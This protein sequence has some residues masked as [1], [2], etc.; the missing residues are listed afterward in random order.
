M[1]AYKI[2]IIL[3]VEQFCG[4]GLKGQLPWRIKEDMEHFKNVTV[5]DGTDEL[6][7]NVVIMGRK[8]FESMKCRPLPRRINIVV[9]RT[10]EPDVHTDDFWI[11]RSLTDAVDSVRI[12]PNVR[13]VF[14]IGGADLFLKG[15]TMADEVYVTYVERPF[16]SDAVLDGKFFVYLRKHFDIFD[17]RHL[18][19]PAAPLRF[20]HYLRHIF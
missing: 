1:S 9:S 6:A 5:G 13:T 4:I 7:V 19:T 14:I 2:A 16:P 11:S 12:F 8:T 10:M 17:E 18:D 3:A 15:I 20:V